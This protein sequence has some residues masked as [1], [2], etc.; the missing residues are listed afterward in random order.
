MLSA[1]RASARVAIAGAI[2]GMSVAGLMSP[3]ASGVGTFDPVVILG[4]G[5]SAGTISAVTVAFP[6]GGTLTA[7][8]SN[9][10]KGVS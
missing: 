5:S 4:T 9:D 7:W 3:A 10:G 2:V 6:D 8:P 1:G